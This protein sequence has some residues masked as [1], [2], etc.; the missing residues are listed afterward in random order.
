MLQDG[1]SEDWQGVTFSSL[2]ALLL[3]N[4]AFS[5]LPC[6][7]ELSSG[8][9]CPLYAIPWGH[10]KIKWMAAMVASGK[11]EACH[12]GDSW[13]WWSASCPCLVSTW[14]INLSEHHIVP[15]KCVQSRA[16]TENLKYRWLSDSLFAVI[17]VCVRETVFIWLNTC[18]SWEREGG[19][20]HEDRP[21]FW[22]KLMMGYEVTKVHGHR[23]P[24]RLQPFCEWNMPSN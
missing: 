6:Y 12:C 13:N 15:Y 18:F 16:P 11:L 8:G 19:H 3:Q 1:A 17:W 23:Q 24:A 14:W 20:L 7:S 21:C 2:I 4:L 5:L 10:C 9:A 22:A